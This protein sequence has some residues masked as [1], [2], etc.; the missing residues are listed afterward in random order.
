[1]RLRLVL[2]AFLILL[3]G[4]VQAGEPQP[5]GNQGYIKGK[6]PEKIPVVKQ[7]PGTNPSLVARILKLLRKPDEWIDNYMFGK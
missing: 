3:P 6:P 7:A 4:F 5:Q 2:L 1:M